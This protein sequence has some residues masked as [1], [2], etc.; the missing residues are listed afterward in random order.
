[1]M[2]NQGKIEDEIK[3]LEL[4]ALSAQKWAEEGKIE[5]WVHKYL[6]SGVGGRTNPEFSEGLKRERRWW[7]GPIELNLTELS[8]AVGPEPGMEYVVEKAH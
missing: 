5:A 7:Q 1:M 2:S 3:R 6:L 4:D 8:P